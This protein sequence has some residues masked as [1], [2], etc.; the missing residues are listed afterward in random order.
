MAIKRPAKICVSD[1]DGTLLDSQSRI[2]PANRQTLTELGKEG[3][4]RVLATGRSLW[5]MQRVIKDDDPFDY[6]IFS[7]G[8]GIMDWRTKELIYHKNLVQDEIHSVYQELEAL[9]LD[10]MIH[11]K[12]PDSHHL[13][14]RAKRELPDFWQRL[15]FYN[16]FAQE[17]KPATLSTLQEATQ[18]LAIAEAG[19]EA[20]YYDLQQKL[21][22]LTVIR[23]T[24]PL[25][26]A[27]LWIEVYAEGVNKGSALNW[28]LERYQLSPADAMVIGND[29]ND[30]DMLELVPHSYVTANAAPELLAKYH[31]VAHH[32]SGGFSEAV[33]H[34]LDRV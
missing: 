27:T 13:H 17:L 28:L 9:S 4:L 22:P 26:F 30:T 15:S 31:P 1:L 29:Y 21:D 11:A 34:W 23:C 32:D 2:S 12:V 20:L 18:F 7:T 3:I 24:S 10:Y 14:Y 8:A 5:S 6:A 33:R 25:D 19:S 16:G